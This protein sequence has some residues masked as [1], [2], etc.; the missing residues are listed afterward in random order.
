[1]AIFYK[2][3]EIKFLIELTAEGFSMDDDDFD[4]EVASPRDSVIGYK[5]ATKSSDTDVVIFQETVT[6][7]G[8]SASAWYAI[9]DTKNLSLGDLRVIA[10]AHVI[11]PNA[12]DGVRND[13]AVAP[14]GKLL[15]P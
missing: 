12:N 14:L 6:S 5:D 15:N 13:V 1:M 11:D 9:V 10:T 4:I 2:G 8:N 3:A 7:G